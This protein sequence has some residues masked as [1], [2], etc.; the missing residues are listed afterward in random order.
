M[1]LK[2]RAEVV[3]AL[4]EGGFCT[5]YGGYVCDKGFPAACSA[6]ITSWIIRNGIT[7]RDDS[8]ITGNGG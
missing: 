4:T 6:C 5:H 7:R 2:E 1:T 8:R 3:A